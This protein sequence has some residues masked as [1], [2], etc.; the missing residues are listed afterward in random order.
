MHAFGYDATLVPY[1][2][3]PNQARDL[4]RDAGYADGLPVTLI[5]PEEL[6]VQAIVISKMLEGVGLKV[7]RQILDATAYNRKIL[8]SHLDRP[9]EQQTWD[10]ALTSHTE[11]ANIPLFTIYQQYILGG[12]FDWGVEKPELQ[13]PL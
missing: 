2:F 13:R 12:P 1:L 11:W 3:D 7:E 9:A 10:I 8:L 6:E 4:L 5:A